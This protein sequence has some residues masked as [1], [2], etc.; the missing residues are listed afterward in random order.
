[1][2]KVGIC[3][4]KRGSVHGISIPDGCGK[5]CMI[6]YHGLCFDCY[7]KLKK[8]IPRNPI[9]SKRKP[10]GELSMFKEIWNERP[11]ISFLTG[12]NLD[13]YENG[14]FISCFAHVFSKKAYPELR[15]DKENIILLTPKEHLL[16]DQGT[17]SQRE[18]YSKE[19]GCEWDIIYEYKDKIRP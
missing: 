1:M 7:L 12:E 9:K 10:T 18:Q 6:T 19:T 8:S 5:E 3:K 4:G 15:L 17:D 2:S 14:F 16:L 13:K 11:H